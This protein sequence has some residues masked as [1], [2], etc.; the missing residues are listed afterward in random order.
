MPRAPDSTLESRLLAAALRLLDRGGEAAITLR[1]VAKE[2]GTTTPTIYERF[3]SREALM[4]RLVDDATDEIMTVLQPTV[5]V[6]EMFHAYLRHSREHPMRLDLM[7][8]TF[9]RRY[10]AGESMPAFELLK[11]RIVREIAVTGSACESLALAVASL[12]FGTAQG[13]NAAGRHDRH[14]A[15][16]QRASLQALRMLLAAHSAGRKSTARRRA[17]IKTRRSV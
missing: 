4:E 17:K 7:V 6:E 9:G 1:A 5:S 13:M 2:A 16:F 11:S 3:S 15:R 8:E 10:V 14:K 12:A